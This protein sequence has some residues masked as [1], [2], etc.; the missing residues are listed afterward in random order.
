MN[1][2]RHL[3]R[4]L[5]SLTAITL[6]LMA[7]TS[8]L[9]SQLLPLAERHPEVISRWLTERAG[10]PVRFERINTDWTKRG[11]LLQLDGLHI[12]EG[13]DAVRIGQAEILIAQ[14]AGLLPGRSF[15]ELRLRNLNLTL[16]RHDDARWQVRGLPGQAASD[17]DPLSA[18][19]KLG[20]LQVI[21]G[22]LNIIA[23]ALGIDAT[24]PDVDLRVRVEGARARIAMQARMQPD[25][26]PLRATLD[27]D[28]RSGNARA[29]AAIRD[30]DLAIWSPLLR[31]DGLML[32]SGNGQIDVWAQ[33]H[34]YR[35]SALTT[36]TALD[37]LLL[38]RMADA[39]IDQVAFGQ[40][41]ARLHWRSDD[42]QWRFDAPEL[43]IGDPEQPQILDGLML[44]GG[45]QLA[46]Y[47]TRIDAGPLLAIAAL[48][49]RLPTALRHWLKAAEP[50]AS[51]HDIA[52]SGTAE[53]G[54]R[55]TLRVDNL[56]FASVGQTPGVAG[57]GGH[58]T[59]DMHGAML[60]LKPDDTV[61]FNWP[62][63]FGAPHHL[64]LDGTL[65]AWWTDA[66]SDIHLTTPALRVDADGYA[67]DLR[68]GLWFHTDGRRPRIDLAATLDATEIPVA[69]RFWVRSNMSEAAIDWLDM[70]LVSGALR[71]GRALVSGELSDWPFDSRGGGHVRGIFE[72]RGELAGAQVRFQP[73]WPVMEAFNGPVRFFND[74]FSLRGKARIGGI[75]L[76]EVHASLPHYS[77]SN[78]T[79]STQ[80]SGDMHDW[81]TLLRQ[82]PLYASHGEILDNLDASGPATSNFNMTLALG[83]GRGAEIAGQAELAGVTL[84][85]NRWE[86][87]FSHLHGPVKYDHHGFASGGLSAVH[88]GRPG[89]LRL[90]AGEGHVRE[91]HAFE[92]EMQARRVHQSQAASQ[93]RERL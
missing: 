22:Q 67:A 74:G 89:L 20:E 8:I 85:E 44:A 39:E 38:Q 80:A 87:E 29:H 64:Q 53:G 30:A 37:H 49:P 61:Q 76:S 81:L 42:G 90:R 59:L 4:W 91:G 60:E 41:Q 83:T 88:D 32:A 69:K 33:L 51:A 17:T 11:P 66:D 84:S 56:H 58:I 12:G 71:N 23:P 1:N 46:L 57:L 63:G 93:G 52:L 19:G 21:H 5:Y 47:A 6:I 75:S 13:E 50:D 79:V 48:S 31:L 73:D 16:E 9:V 35:L 54:L 43:R 7:L 27:L 34:G 25:A 70:A 72:A 55:G 36:T 92:A 24:I 45:S 10:L 62:T 65:A 26:A 40:V 77:Q 3:T 68:G 14:Y 28:R 86:L 18:L 82:S 78:L 2:L 15:T